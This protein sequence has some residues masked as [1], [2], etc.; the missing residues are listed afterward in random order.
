M[1]HR[2]IR[3][4]GLALLAL[5]L[6]WTSAEAATLKETFKQTYPL[7]AGGEVEVRNTN[8]GITVEA[9]DRNEVQ[10]EAIKQVKADSDAKAKEILQKIRID[11]QAGS[12]LVRI[13]TRLPKEEGGL[14]KLLTG[15]STNYSVT[16]KIR[17]PRDVVAGL[18]STN[19]G[20]R[21]VGTRGKAVLETTNGG[22]SVERVAGDIRMRSTNGGLNVVEA[23]GNLDGITTNGGITAHFTEVDGDISLST[24]NG[25]VTLKVPRDIRASVDVATSNGSIRSELEVEGGQKGRKSLTGDIN[26]GGGSLKIRST[27]G[28]VRIVAE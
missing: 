26:G 3:I 19:G 4:P 10:V 21:L 7:G 2:K 17:A 22:A 1:I 6:T 24:T 20:V 28:G 5:A 15:N 16:Y 27:N 11:V 8:G 23:S 25:G 9:W 14:F 18:H 13:E 12:G